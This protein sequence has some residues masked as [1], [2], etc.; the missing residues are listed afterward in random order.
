MCLFSFKKRNLT[1]LHP[2]TEAVLVFHWF[3]FHHVVL[4]QVVLEKQLQKR[5]IAVTAGGADYRLALTRTIHAHGRSKTA[6]RQKSRTLMDDIK[7]R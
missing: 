6:G 1:H 7:T 2:L 3:I 4:H 5:D